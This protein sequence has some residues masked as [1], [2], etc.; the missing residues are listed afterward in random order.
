MCWSIRALID[1]E[2]F[3]ISLL[4]NTIDALIKVTLQSLSKEAHA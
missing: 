1:Q 3:I 2:I 4:L